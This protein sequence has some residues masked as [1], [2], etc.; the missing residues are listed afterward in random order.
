MRRTRRRTPS[1][2]TSLNDQPASLTVAIGYVIDGNP[3]FTA[4]RRRAA[5][6]L[7]IDQLAHGVVPG[8]DDFRGLSQ[9][10]GHHLVVDHDQPE[11]VARRT[12]LDENVGMLLAGPRQ[13][14]IRAP[15]GLSTPTVM[16][17]PCSPRVG[18]TTTSPTS[19]RNP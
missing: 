2:S 7:G 5:P 12:L 17:L 18:L 15:P 9:C 1:G 10:G 3:G 13:G 14:R 16:P 8:A 19:S 11:V 6:A 4:G